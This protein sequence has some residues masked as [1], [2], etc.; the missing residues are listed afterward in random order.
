[1]I[2]G[3]NL[4][5]RKGTRVPLHDTSPTLIHPFWVLSEYLEGS[6]S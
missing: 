5:K 4:A 3:I 1:M 6:G 2:A